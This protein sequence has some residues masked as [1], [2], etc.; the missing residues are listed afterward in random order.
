[1]T[2]PRSFFS[3][4]LSVRGQRPLD[5]GRPG[6]TVGRWGVGGGEGWGEGN[7]LAAQ[8]VMCLYIVKGPTCSVHQLDL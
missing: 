4:W 1:M 5:L 2:P 3:G 8:S 7:G 6:T